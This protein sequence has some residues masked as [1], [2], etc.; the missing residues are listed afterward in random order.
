MKYVCDSPWLFE[1]VVQK[2]VN[3]Y[4]FSPYLINT[5]KTTIYQGR[6]QA[7]ICKNK[8]DISLKHIKMKAYKDGLTV[9]AEQCY[10]VMKN[11]GEDL[12]FDITL[13]VKY[14]SP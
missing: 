1:Q 10:S 14:L 2:G 4:Q 13:F 12:Y 5:G 3:L 6:A 7:N 11:S 8:V 9:S